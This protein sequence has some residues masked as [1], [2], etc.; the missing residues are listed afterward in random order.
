MR[1]FF[2]LLFCLIIIQSKAQFLMD[3]VD[4]T[5]EVGKSVLSVSQRFNHIRIG[6]YI[7]PQFQLAQQ[8]GARSYNGGDFAPNVNNRFML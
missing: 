4:T 3:M 5:T 7:Q 1:I 6:G 8:K 2:I